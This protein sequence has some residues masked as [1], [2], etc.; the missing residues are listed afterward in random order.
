MSGSPLFMM[1]GA[2][3]PDVP[4]PFAVLMDADDS[5]WADAALLRSTGRALLG[6]GCRYF[7]CAGR[8]AERLHDAL[9]DVIVEDG[10][11]GVPTTYHDSEGAEDVADFFRAV[12]T[13]GMKGALVVV[14]NTHGWES[15]LTPW[16]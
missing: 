1:P 9:D 8:A 6:A 11:A 16:T 15:H 2:P 4:S 7:V 12:A 5:D 13:V 10:Y 3:L 14:R